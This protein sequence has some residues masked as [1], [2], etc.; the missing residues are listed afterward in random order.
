MRKDVFDVLCVL[1]ILCTEGLPEFVVL[2]TVTDLD[3]VSTGEVEE[4]V[5]AGEGVEFVLLRNEAIVRVSDVNALFMPSAADI[6]ACIK[7][8]DASERILAA[9]CADAVTR[10]CFGVTKD[11]RALLLVVLKTVETLAITMRKPSSVAILPNVKKGFW[12]S[13]LSFN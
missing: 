11:C 2:V 12:T 6:E 8:F 3:S 10:A 7:R 4:S 9:L 13:L 1:L 5:T